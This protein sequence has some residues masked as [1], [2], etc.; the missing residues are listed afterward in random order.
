MVVFQFKSQLVELYNGWI[1]VRYLVVEPSTHPDTA[2]FLVVYQVQPFNLN[3]YFGIDYRQAVPI[4]MFY[5]LLHHF[6]RE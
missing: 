2:G 3:H 4:S 5:K 1:L 6:Q